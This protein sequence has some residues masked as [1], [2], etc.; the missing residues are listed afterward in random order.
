MLKVAPVWS[1]TIGGPIDD[2]SNDQYAWI[3]GSHGDRAEAAWYFN[4][5][6]ETKQAK[7]RMHLDLVDPD[8]MAVARLVGFGARVVG[9]HCL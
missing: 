4:R 6:P 3:G 8:L 7:N 5:A 2:G 1:Q 9:N